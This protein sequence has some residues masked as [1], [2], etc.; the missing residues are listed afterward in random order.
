[1]LSFVVPVYCGSIACP[2]SRSRSN[3]P[4][5]DSSLPY[6]VP[7]E[8]SRPACAYQPMASHPTRD[9]FALW[10]ARCYLFVVFQVLTYVLEQVTKGKKDHHQGPHLTK[11]SQEEIRDDGKQDA[12]SRA[13]AHHATVARLVAL[14]CGFALALL[15]KGVVSLPR[16]SARFESPTTRALA[17][18]AV[19]NAKLERGGESFPD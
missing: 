15:V 6:V 16:K 5:G 2:F 10:F 12:A 19:P 7:T 8:R 11:H 3:V 4:I 14:I 13:C 18:V 17:R 1:M 9:T